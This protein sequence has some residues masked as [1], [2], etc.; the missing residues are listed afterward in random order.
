MSRS[1]RSDRTKLGV[2]KNDRWGNGG[3]ALV[4]TLVAVATCNFLM[5]AISFR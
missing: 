5:A 1:A 4:S 3:R 2:L